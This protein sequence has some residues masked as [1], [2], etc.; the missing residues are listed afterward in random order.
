LALPRVLAGILENNQTDKGIKV[1]KAL[2]RYT[3][4]EMID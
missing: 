1:P 3:G 2:V 4:F